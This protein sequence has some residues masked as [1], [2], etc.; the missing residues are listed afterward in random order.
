MLPGN[1]SLKEIL[2]GEASPGLLQSQVALGVQ[3]AKPFAGAR[4][5][6]ASN[7]SMSH[8]EFEG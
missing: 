1:E 6:L 5:V 2:W 3:R 8:P 7:L 4:G